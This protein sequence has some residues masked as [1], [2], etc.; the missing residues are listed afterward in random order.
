[1]KFLTG[2]RVEVGPLTVD[3]KVRSLQ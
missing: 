3:N 2:H 1:L